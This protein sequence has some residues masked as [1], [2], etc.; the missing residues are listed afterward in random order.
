MYLIFT[1]EVQLCVDSHQSLFCVICH[2]LWLNRTLDFGF[3]RGTFSFPYDISGSV[4]L[5]LA[6]LM[7]PDHGNSS[8]LSCISGAISKMNDFDYLCGTRGGPTQHLYSF[9]NEI[10]CSITISLS[11]SPSIL[12]MRDIYVVPPKF[13]F[14]PV[15][16][17]VFII[18]NIIMHR[19][20]HVLGTSSCASH[21]KY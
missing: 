16:L 13:H 7:E 15:I 14:V 18:D 17:I 4:D 2:L 20:T 11:P 19:I 5:D 21:A 3:Q 6:F 8:S 1:F 9:P 10:S 12:L